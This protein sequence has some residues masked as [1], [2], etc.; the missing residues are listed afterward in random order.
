[1]KFYFKI[2]IFYFICIGKIFSTTL[3]CET[4][5]FTQSKSPYNTGE[6][7]KEYKPK[8]IIRIDKKEILVAATSVGSELKASSSK[9]SMISNSNVGIVGIDLER[10]FTGASSIAIHPNKKKGTIVEQTALFVSTLYF[11]CKE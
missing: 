8:L 5:Y 6:L 9:Y 2:F 1:M 4:I 10:R 3:E 7:L 11:E